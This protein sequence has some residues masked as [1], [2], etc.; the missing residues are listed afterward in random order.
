MKTTAKRIRTLLLSGVF[1]A[2]VATPVSGEASLDCEYK[3]V[4]YGLFCN[5]G[6]DIEI[7]SEPDGTCTASCGQG[8]VEV[9]C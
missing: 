7:C 6:S 2:L 1:L 5:D 9:T 8:A 3:I 4:H